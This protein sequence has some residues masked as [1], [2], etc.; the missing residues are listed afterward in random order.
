[1][2]ASVLVELDTRPPI[3]TISAPSRVFPPDYWVVSVTAD[4]DIKNASAALVDSIGTL[5][6]LGSQRIGDRSLDILVPTV[7][8]SSGPASLM[9]SVSDA[10]LNFVRTQISIHIDR[11]RG[12]DVDMV[13][14]HVYDVQVTMSSAY[15][16]DLGLDHAYFVS[17]EVF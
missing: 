5:T 12:F 15:E 14:E 3:L 2:T 4:E 13:V 8:V 16:V 11:P 10:V 1:M 6:R 17:L 9:L 7:G